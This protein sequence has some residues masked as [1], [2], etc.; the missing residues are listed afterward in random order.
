MKTTTLRH[1]PSCWYCNGKTANAGK[2]CV[3]CLD[4]GLQPI[5]DTLRKYAKPEFLTAATRS[6]RLTVRE[7]KDALRRIFA[8]LE[9]AR[10]N[11]CP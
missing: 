10:A 11:G 8:R 2:A 6:R 4:S 3:K 9:A 1:K 5:P 7:A